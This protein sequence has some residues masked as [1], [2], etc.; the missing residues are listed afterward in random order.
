MHH[1]RLD[2]TKITFFGYVLLLILTPFLLLQNYLQQAIGELSDLRFEIFHI[3]IPILMLL[4]FL[5]V[6]IICIHTCMN[7]HKYRLFV[8]ISIPLLLMLAYSTTDF[9]H[10][11]QF[12]DLQHNWH[13]FAYGIFAYIAYLF[14]WDKGTVNRRIVWKVFLLAF[15]ISLSD[16][17]IQVFISS[18]VFDLSD[19]AKDLFGCMLGQVFMQF[20]VLKGRKFSQYKLFY[21][22]YMEPLKHA[23][24][25]LVILLITSW[26]FLLISSLFTNSIYALPVLV[27]G[28]SGFFLLLFLFKLC[29]RKVNRYLVFVVIGALLVWY[30]IACIKPEKRVTYIS[31]HILLYNSFPVVYADVFIMP[32]G[33]FRPVDKKYFFNKTDKQRIEQVNPDILLIGTGS[34]GKGGM[35]FNDQLVTE[36]RFNYFY[37]Q[38]YQVIKLP[39]KKAIKKYHHLHELNS[40]VVF[41]ILNS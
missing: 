7:F 21:R 5:P 15:L 41:I 14:Y 8:L 2:N 17:L 38:T 6:L 39:T 28:V 40:R 22:T 19:V 36:I 27:A 23:F 33:C 3:E 34:K 10:Y 9:Y 20:Y 32:N 16:E 35:G 18:R 30:G 13:Y 37:D 12:F 11:H 24:P 31:E 4:F 29:Y 1:K 26:L 25:L